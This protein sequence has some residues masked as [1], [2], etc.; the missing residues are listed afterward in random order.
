MIPSTANIE[1]GGTGG[2][3][4]SATRCSLEWFK[5]LIV[6]RLEIAIPWRVHPCCAWS[7]P[8]ACLRPPWHA[9]QRQGT[10]VEVS[11][12]LGGVIS[13]SS[14]RLVSRSVTGTLGRS[15]SPS[16]FPNPQRQGTSV[17]DSRSLG[18]VISP[19]PG[20][21]V[22]RSVTGTLGRSVSPS[23]FPTPYCGRPQ[24][25][26]SLLFAQSIVEPC[27]RL[28]RSSLLSFVESTQ[29]E[30]GTQPLDS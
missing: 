27:S 3:P 9:P 12:S 14:G 16:L 2:R 13:P 1:L 11:R 20:R 24:G 8:L 17:E 19:S 7:V 21:L 10:S 28:E 30:G 23:L 4:R 25:P 15:V 26:L 29:F 22:S 6:N 5:I 18:G